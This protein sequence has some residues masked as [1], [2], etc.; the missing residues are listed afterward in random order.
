MNPDP[1][2]PVDIDT[3]FRLDHVLDFLTNLALCVAVTVGAIGAA[4]IFWRLRSPE[5]YEERFATPARLLRWRFW[6]HMSWQSYASA[7]VCPPRSRSRAATT[8]AVK[9]CR[10][11]GFIQSCWEQTYL[12]PPCY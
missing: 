6:A 9:S 8:K 2:A 11:V 10:H 3:P 12:A 7:A 5:T 1:F 4:L